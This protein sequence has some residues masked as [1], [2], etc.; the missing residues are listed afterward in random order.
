MN[1]CGTRPDSKEWMLPATDLLTKLWV[2]AGSGNFALRISFGESALKECSATESAEYFKKLEFIQLGHDISTS[3]TRLYYT[4]CGNTT[5]RMRD[6]HS[7]RV[8]RGYGM[9]KQVL[10]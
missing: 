6:S 5:P 4:I 3:R 1:L 9:S 2:N 7:S 8:N 10:S